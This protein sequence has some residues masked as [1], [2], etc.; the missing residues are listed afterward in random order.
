MHAGYPV[1]MDTS[2]A[3]GLVNPGKARTSGLWGAV[4]ELGH[5]QQRGV[6][7]FPPNTTECT[8]N[9][10]SVY[11]HETVL[12]LDRAKAH[13]NMSQ[14]NRRCRARDYAQGGR[15]LGK[16]SMWVALE[17]YMQVSRSV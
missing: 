9:L 16:W 14:E 15:Q 6:W 12:G 13:P 3:A 1:M 11:V 7:E 5:N 2:A 8:C 17:T 10:W 4:H